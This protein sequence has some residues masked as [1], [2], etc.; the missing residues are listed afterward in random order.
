MTFQ[1]YDRSET[2]RRPF[3]GFGTR[4]MPEASIQP[5]PALNARPS[6]RWSRSKYR[7]MAGASRLTTEGAPAIARSADNSP[8]KYVS[9]TLPATTA[10]AR[11][12]RSAVR[13]ADW[14]WLQASAPATVTSSSTAS[15]S[16]IASWRRLAMPPRVNASSIS[17][18]GPGSCDL[19]WGRF[20]RS[21]GHRLAR[22]AGGERRASVAEG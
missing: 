5:S 22:C 1:K 7:F 15:S 19:P 16:P 8:R 17:G 6:P 9:T 20:T 11:S 12:L 18:G 2:S 10:R 14:Y 21:P 3:A 13:C 4:T